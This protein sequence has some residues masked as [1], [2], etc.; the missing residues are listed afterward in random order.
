MKALDMEEPKKLVIMIFD[1]IKSAKLRFALF[2]RDLSYQFSFSPL[3]LPLAKNSYKHKCND[4]QNNFNKNFYW[5]ILVNYN[6]TIIYI[7]N[8]ELVNY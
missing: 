7:V 8:F 3:P 5:L 4:Y 1:T 2:I 6:N